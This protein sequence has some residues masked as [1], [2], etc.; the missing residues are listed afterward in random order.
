MVD[1]FL[2]SVIVLLIFNL[3]N[4]QTILISISNPS[5]NTYTD[6]Q[7]LHSTELRC[8]CSTI[9]IPHHRFISLSPTLHQICSSDFIT[10]RW[11][12]TLQQITIYNA[13]LD[14]RN[15]A[16]QQ[17][18]ILSKLC[19]LSNETVTNAI[20]EFLSQSLIVS[21]LLTETDFNIQINKTLI[22]FYQ[23]TIVYFRHLMEVVDLHIQVDQPFMAT[24]SNYHFTIDLFSTQN[25]IT[26]T[27]NNQ[28]VIEVCFCCICLSF[29]F[30]L[31]ILILG[32]SFFNL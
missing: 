15:K 5:L 25:I 22:Q 31:Y 29:D 6:L 17:Y 3:L 1:C 10:D 20:N 19:Q 27:T 32:N 21:N 23:L 7:K 8:P 14:W 26:N 4:T 24:S 13:D 2:V 18:N 30:I 12:S 28:Q 11:L 16:Y 9:A